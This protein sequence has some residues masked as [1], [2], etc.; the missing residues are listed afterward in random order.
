MSWRFHGRAQVDPRYPSAWAVCDRCGMLYN[1]RDLNKE[2]DWRGTVL[3]PTGSVVCVR[4]SDES[5][6]QLRAMALP[7]DPPDVRNPRPEPYPLD[8]HNIRIT[9]A[10]VI[11]VSESGDIRITESG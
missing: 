6:E 2:Y 7:V 10:G 4:C 3:S 8:E 5:Q 9:E 11:R 1:R